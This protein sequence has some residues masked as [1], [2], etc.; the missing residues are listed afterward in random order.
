M[1]DF[2][3]DALCALRDRVSALACEVL[4][5]LRDDGRLTPAERAAQV[6]EAGGS[7]RWTAATTRRSASTACG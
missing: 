2:L 6:R 5:P 3:P 4:T 1:P 7:R